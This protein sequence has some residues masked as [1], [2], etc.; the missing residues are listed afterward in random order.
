MYDFIFE[1]G[2][3]PGSLNWQYP[4]RKM[5]RNAGASKALWRKNK[6]EDSVILMN[7]DRLYLALVN[8]VSSFF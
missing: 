3:K 1:I 4:G 2:T 8:S 5:E 6:R 7:F